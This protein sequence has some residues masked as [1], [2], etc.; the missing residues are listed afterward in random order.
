M[1]RIPT[2]AR[3][4]VK[5]RSEGRCERC[6]SVGTDWHHRRRRNVSLGHDPH[7][8]C[9]GVWLCRTCHD[10][11]HGHPSK[12]MKEGF[13]VSSYESSPWSIPLRI[14]TREWQ[15]NDCEGGFTLSTTR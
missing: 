10:D 1:S 15:T 13:I 12:A 4:A 6:N 3:E 14:F 11:M 8:P 7:C 2:A 5:A 9:N